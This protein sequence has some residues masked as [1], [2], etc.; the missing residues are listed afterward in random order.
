MTSKEKVQ[1]IV[2]K[3]NNSYSQLRKNAT[4]KEFKTFLNFLAD[5]S[6]KKQRKLV[7]LSD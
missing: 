5:E 6:N 1:K 2:N 4:N 7:G 3:Y